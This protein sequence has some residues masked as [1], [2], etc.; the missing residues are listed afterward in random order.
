M[1]EHFVDN[2]HLTIFFSDTTNN[3]GLHA[4]LPDNFSLFYN[5][6]ISNEMITVKFEMTTNLSR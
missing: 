4:K 5:N 6:L 1:I 3:N 2:K